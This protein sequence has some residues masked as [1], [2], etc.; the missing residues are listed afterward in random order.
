MASPQQ[1][2]LAAAIQDVAEQR[3]Y[4]KAERKPKD[5]G[6]IT[7]LCFTPPEVEAMLRIAF[8]PPADH[9][10]AVCVRAPSIPKAQSAS[11]LGPIRQLWIAPASS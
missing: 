4:P 2:V 9:L 8:F 11:G 1:F 3:H 7:R 6:D 10:R 5:I